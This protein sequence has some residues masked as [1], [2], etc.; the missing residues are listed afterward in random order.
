MNA[1]VKSAYSA[2]LGGNRQ[3]LC[4]SLVR[5]GARA[6]R[7]GG[8]HSDKANRCI[9]NGGKCV[10]YYAV[11][12]DYDAKTDTFGVGWKQR[13]P[14]AHVDEIAF[15]DSVSQLIDALEQLARAFL[16]NDALCHP[17]GDAGGAH[18]GLSK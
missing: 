3:T 4:K 2:W 11:L 14:A 13:I 16:P 6:V 8:D 1:L 9:I 17:A 12:T 18:R 5:N 15:S 10:G 7:V